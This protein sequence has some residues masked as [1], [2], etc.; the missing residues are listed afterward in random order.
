LSHRHL[1]GV[2][3]DFPSAR[4]IFDE[5]VASFRLEDRLNFIE[6]DFLD[7]P[8]P[9]ADVISFMCA[10]VFDGRN[11]QIR[12]EL[13]AKTHAATPP[14]GALIVYDAMF[15]P[16]LRK[17]TGNRLG[18]HRNDNFQS[19]LSSLNVMLESREGYESSTAA[20]T[21]LLRAGGFTAVKVRHLIGPTS[22]VFGSNQAGCHPAID[23]GQAAQT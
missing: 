15:L 10:H 14:G 4:P 18:K 8:L 13:V 5:Y 2:G 11:H 7:V 20:C 17:W 12:Q 16:G 21:D 19:L 6:G 9:N 23:A 1:R 22:A 3:F